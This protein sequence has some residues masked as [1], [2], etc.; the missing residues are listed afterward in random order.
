MS[1]AR[2]YAV[3]PD[4]R[5]R[6]GSRALQSWKSG[7][8]QNLLRNLQWVLATDHGFLNQGT[9]SKSDRTGFLIFVLVLVSPCDV[10]LNLAQTSVV[11][12]RPSVPYG[13]NFY[14]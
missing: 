10:T 12:S 6:S 7:H 14:R 4:P 8:F 1:D 13:A 5:S 3:R 9:I 11:K 2:R